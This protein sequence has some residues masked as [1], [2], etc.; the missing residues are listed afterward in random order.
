[1]FI[2]GEI[3][4]AFWGNEAGFSW[5]SYILGHQVEGH[6]WSLPLAIPASTMAGKYLTSTTCPQQNHKRSH[7]NGTVKFGL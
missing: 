6:T 3:L 1:M 7:T 4:L 5:L 2:L